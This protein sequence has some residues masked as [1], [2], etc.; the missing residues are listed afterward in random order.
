MRI[1]EWRCETGLIRLPVLILPPVPAVAVE[2]EAVTALI[3]TGSTVSG[4]G[5]GTATSLGLARRGQQPIGSDQDPFEAGSYEFRIGLVPDYSP[6]NQPRRP[7]VFDPVVGIE[8]PDHFEFDA[9]LGMDVLG[10]CDFAM[11]RRGACRLVFG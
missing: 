8:L 3:D 9:L 4:V 1:I 7:F 6:P 11:N 10:Q 5:P 2:G